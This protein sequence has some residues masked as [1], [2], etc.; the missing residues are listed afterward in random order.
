MAARALRFA[1]LAG[2]FP[3]P[4]ILSSHHTLI[5]RLHTHVATARRAVSAG[6]DAL[7]TVLFTLLFTSVP[8]EKGG[9]GGF[10][11]GRGGGAG[12]GG[13]GGDL[14]CMGVRLDWGIQLK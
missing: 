8:R 12:G 3:H 10:G 2:P 7:G 5:F 4:R 6:A 1:L 11:A 9:P 13:R 14:M